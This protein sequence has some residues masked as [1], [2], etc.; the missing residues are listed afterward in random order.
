MTNLVV[1]SHGFAGADSVPR[2]PTV[3]D[4]RAALPGASAE[5]VLEVA[6]AG[7][8]IEQ[9]QKQFI[10]RLQ[11]ERPQEVDTAPRPKGVPGNGS[12]GNTV[13][14]ASTAGGR[15]DHASASGEDFCSLVEEQTAKGMDRRQAIQY[16]TRRH[17]AAHQE[18]LRSTQRSKASLYLLERKIEVFS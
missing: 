18:Y 6:S 13:N 10:Q 15:N 1:G 4:Y 17:P 12:P 7:C 9:A 2:T 5:F 11:T 16:V 14:L 3:A 8:S